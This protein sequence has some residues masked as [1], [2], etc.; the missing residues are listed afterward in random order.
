MCEWDDI[1]FVFICIDWLIYIFMV[2]YFM[3]YG[4]YVV[5][6]VFVVMIV[7][8]CWKLV[9][10]VEKIRQ[11]CMMFENCCYDLFVLI[12]FNMV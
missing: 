11:Y 8:E 3:E 7:E 1:D 12:M 4:K 10:M 6:E 9:D 2:V 5:I